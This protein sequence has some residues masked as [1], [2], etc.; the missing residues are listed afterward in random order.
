MGKPK[1]PKAPEPIDPNESTMK[2]LFGEEGTG[3]GITDPELQRRLLEAEATFGPEYIANELA[4][5]EFALFGGPDQSGLIELGQQA[6][7][8][9]E[10]LRADLARRQREADITDVE[11]LGGRAT[12]AFRAS[13][14]ARQKVLD[15][16]QALTDRLF[17]RA[18]R[19]TPQQERM[20]MQSAREAGS[21]RG[22]EMDNVTIF[23]EALGREDLMRQNRAEAMAAGGQLFGQLQ[24]TSPDA[25]QVVT[26][27]PAGAMA[28]QQGFA[29][30]AQGL[31]ANVGPALF[32]PDAGINLALQNNANQAN[33]NASIYGAQAANYGAVVGGLLGSAGQAFG[34]GFGG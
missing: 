14:P 17:D 33:Y 2:F 7:P 13:D 27:R 34:G 9:A 18:S 28:Q 8:G 10:A 6:A 5:Q 4:R 19:I 12:E 15:Q 31:G 11:D 30:Q 32:S 25:F 1:A 20:A 24:A 22:R 21:A 26:G 23:S 29:N 16:Q 3:R